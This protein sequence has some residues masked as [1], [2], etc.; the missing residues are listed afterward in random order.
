MILAV[1]MSFADLIAAADRVALDVF[2]EAT[3]ITY[4]PD[5]GAAVEVAGIFDE[6]YV[7]A[8]GAAQAA[9]EAVGPAVFLRL[10]DLPVD[11]EA[12]DPTLTIR[13]VEY[14]VRERRPDGMGGIV[15][16]LRRAT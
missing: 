11:P 1:V 13:G 12:D 5:G 6:N 2:A 16:E 7:L 4:T 15:L 8:K 9:V 14:T 3:P 10:S